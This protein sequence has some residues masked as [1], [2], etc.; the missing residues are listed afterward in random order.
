MAGDFLGP[1][2]A[3]I[4]KALRALDLAAT[5]AGSLE[6]SHPRDAMSRARLAASV[7]RVKAV[8]AAIVAAGIRLPPLRKIWQTGERFGLGGEKEDLL[9]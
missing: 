3:Q 1:L 8:R 7:R 2:D 6:R 5:I 4:A 9:P